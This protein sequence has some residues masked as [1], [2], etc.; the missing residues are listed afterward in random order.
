MK[1]KLG[2]T[3][4]ELLVVIAIIAILAAI[5]FPVFAK[6]REKARQISCTSNMKQIGL[7]LLQYV[8]DNDETWPTSTYGGNPQKARGWAGKVYPYLKS[9][10]VYKCPDE[11]V[12]VS[13]SGGVTYYPTSYGLNANLDGQTNGGR[14]AADNSPAKTVLLFECEGQ[15]A[16]LLSPLETNSAGGWGPDR[17][18]GYLDQAGPNIAYSSGPMGNPVPASNG[19]GLPAKGYWVSATG[20]HTDLSNFAMA[21]GHVKAL[22]GTSVSP[23]Q[24][25]SIETD[26]QYNDGGGTTHSAGTGVSGFGATF[27]HI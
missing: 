7:G 2:F 24:S 22:R 5:L 6:A 11:S 19:C 9:V 20:R 16:D 13:V 15:G 1:K 8:Q 26:P 3:L 10:G 23:G 17:C 18:A 4:I 21:D 27:S 12:S 14:L 25:A